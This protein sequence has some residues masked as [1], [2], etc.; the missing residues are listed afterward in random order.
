MLATSLNSDYNND[1]HD[2]GAIEHQ[3]KCLAEAK[4]THTQ[5]IHDWEGEYMYS[6]CE[7]FQARDLLN[8]Y[9][10]KAH[11]IHATE[12]GD[13]SK[14][15]DGRKVP[16]VRE[17]CTRIRKDYTSLNS[18]LRQAG[19]DLLKNRIDLCAAI[20]AE[21]MVLHMQLPFGMFSRSKDD[22]E[23]YYR[24]VY[25]SF[26]EVEPYARAAGVRIAL[27]NLLFTPAH[28]QLD[29]FER[30]FDRYDNGF[31]GL[32]Y[33]SGHASVMF[34]NNYYELLEKY[35]DRLFVTHLQDTDSLDPALLDDDAAVVKADK[36]AIPFTGVLDW[37]KV[38][39]WVARSPVDLPAD[40]EICIKYGESFDSKQQEMDLL[41]EVHAAAER[42]HQLVLDEKQKT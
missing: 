24:A 11:T 9:G 28:Y 6:R 31:V 40:F 34:Q 32:C 35:H 38:A 7:M 27:E 21:A 29:K 8:H 26:D 20:G 22:M 16:N 12:G 3:V 39:Y 42:F 10:I 23:E 36:H 2:W 17:R 30:M 4:F 1:F 19:V 14:M 5:W 33:D 25:K 37:Q 13:R 15:V 18:Y 41:G